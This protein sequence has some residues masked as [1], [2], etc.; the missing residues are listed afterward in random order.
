MKEEKLDEDLQKNEGDLKHVQQVIQILMNQR[1]KLNSLLDEDRT[2][3][4]KNN[5]KLKNLPKTDTGKKMEKRVKTREDLDR[6]EKEHD[7]LLWN[8][9][10][11]QKTAEQIITIMTERKEKLERDKEKINE[12]LKETERQ[13]EETQKKL[14]LEQQVREE[15][16]NNPSSNDDK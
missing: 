7:E 16:K 11:L 3:R 6:R 12:H 14:Q 13:R 4:E 9:G 10:E 8:T 15:E 1:D 5:E 2:Q